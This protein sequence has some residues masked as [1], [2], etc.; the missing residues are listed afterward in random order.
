MAC[1]PRDVI[2]ALRSKTVARGCT[3]QEAATAQAKADELCEKYGV[4]KDFG[5]EA[6][7]AKQ[8]GFRHTDH[9]DGSR[10]Y[11]FGFGATDDF[12]REA[13]R[14]AAEMARQ[15]ANRQRSRQSGREE[16]LRKE[17]AKYKSVRE[18]A[19]F[20]LRPGW[21]NKATGKPLSNAEVAGI[22]R[23]IM[24]SKTSAASVAWYKVQMRKE[25][26]L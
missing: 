17:H 12:L 22:V 4:P 3:P 6:P 9:P 19:E 18:C 15:Q 5:K 25:G 24:G 23:T 20:Y 16:A 26:Q 2:A 21:R 11:D 1:D 13:M 7:R 14:H 10:S 8:D